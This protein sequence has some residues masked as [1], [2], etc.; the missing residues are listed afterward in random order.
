M[1]QQGIIIIY[2]LLFPKKKKKKISQKLKNQINNL[3]GLKVIVSMLYLQMFQ[4]LQENLQIQVLSFLPIPL[5]FCIPLFPFYLHSLFQL[6][7]TKNC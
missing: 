1:D 5:Y 4:N 7:F 6:F 3:D 2:F